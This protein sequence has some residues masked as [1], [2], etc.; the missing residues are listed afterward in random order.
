MMLIESGDQSQTYQERIKRKNS[1][2][3]ISD[4]ADHF[5]ISLT[6]PRRFSNVPNYRQATDVL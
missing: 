4:K 3:F 1:A 2:V 5:E 6:N